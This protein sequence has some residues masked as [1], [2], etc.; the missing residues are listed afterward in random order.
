MVSVSCY[1]M[2]LDSVESKNDRLATTKYPEPNFLVFPMPGYLR[3]APS[4]L[5]QIPA[6][7]SLSNQLMLRCMV[8]GTA[9]H[10]EYPV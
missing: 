2:A 1:V 9:Y 7:S 4:M 3:M 5:L 10:C 6:H 8:D